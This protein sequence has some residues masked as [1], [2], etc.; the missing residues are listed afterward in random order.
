MSKCKIQ[1]V[2]AHGRA[3]PDDN[4]AVCVAVF[5]SYNRDGSVREER[6][7]PICGEHLSR[8]PN[9]PSFDRCGRIV[10]TWSF[11]PLAEVA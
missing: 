2:D 6:R 4:P 9:E 7:F 1:W 5:R 11:E 3:T 10:S 8:A